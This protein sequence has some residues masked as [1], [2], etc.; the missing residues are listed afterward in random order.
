MITESKIRFYTNK[1]QKHVACSYGYN[2]VCA[3]DKF[4]KPF[5]SFLGNSVYN[6]TNS[7]IKENKYCPDIMQKSF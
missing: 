6:F 4:S 3:D 7:M 2:I 1:C 5:K